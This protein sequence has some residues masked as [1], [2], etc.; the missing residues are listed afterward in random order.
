MAIQPL[1][2]HITSDWL[3]HI[4]EERNST[5]ELNKEHLLK[6]IR[7]RGQYLSRLDEKCTQSKLPATQ[8]QKV[9]YGR[10]GKKTL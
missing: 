7:D 9:G 4:K 3:K 2:F 5:N 1:P 8:A 10:F 6:L